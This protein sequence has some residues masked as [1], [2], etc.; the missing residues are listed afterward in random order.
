M[1]R[2][3]DAARR[4]PELPCGRRDPHARGIWPEEDWTASE[5]LALTDAAAHLAGMG[6]A[7]IAPESARRAWR[8]HGENVTE[9]ARMRREQE[10][11]W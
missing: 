2:R 1:Q 7:P 5:L 9:L 4:L 6:Y 11:Y 10:Q 8:R 3:Q